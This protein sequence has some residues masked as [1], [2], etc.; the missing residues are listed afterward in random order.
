MLY[1]QIRL[2]QADIDYMDEY[3]VFTLGD[4]FPLDKMQNLV[5]GLHDNDQH[6]IVMV[7]PGETSCYLP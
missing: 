4:R 7:D 2:T 1:R 6:Y 5:N 3:K